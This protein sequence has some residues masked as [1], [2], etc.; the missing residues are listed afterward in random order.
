MEVGR[1]AK[2]LAA[3]PCRAGELP[4]DDGDYASHEGKIRPVRC[5]IITICMSMARWQDWVELLITSSKQE[6]R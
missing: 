6:G 4:G 3:M 1:L 5:S 2:S